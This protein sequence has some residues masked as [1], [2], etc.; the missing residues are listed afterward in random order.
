MT[1]IN[2]FRPKEIAI[3][4]AL[5]RY[6]FLTYDQM[7]RLGIANHTSN[8][9]S[10]TKGLRE[11]KR[12]Y[13]KKIPHRVG[14]PIKHFLTKRGKDAL[15]ELY[16]LQESDINYP[17]GSILTDTQD[18]KHRTSIISIQIEV[19]LAAQ[20]EG[21]EMLFCDRYFDTTGNNRVDKN[22]KSK[23][24][25][26][27]T[28]TQT[29]KADLIFSLQ[30]PKQQEYYVLELENGKDSAK[31]VDKCINHAK[32]LLKGSLNEKLGF[33]T[34]YRALWVFEYK[35]I[36]EKVIVKLQSISLF[37]HLHEYFLFK[38]LNQIEKEI[39]SGWKNV[40][41]R[42]RNLYYRD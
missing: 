30:T 18:Q 31:A 25:F 10:V 14:T 17:I 4:K 29:V 27:C 35:S 20:A 13:I 6:K 33:S 11:V 38:P 36:M 40:S 42:E 22:L 12:P 5:A 37:E 7:I 1:K 34:G 41:A 26:H 32:A 9:S 8:L 3:L 16:H 39:L 21:L 24:A 2:R 23:T 15:V 28:D 19:D